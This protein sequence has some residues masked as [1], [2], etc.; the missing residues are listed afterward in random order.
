MQLLMIPGHDPS[1]LKSGDAGNRADE[2]VVEVGVAIS[3]GPLSPAR[4]EVALR[5]NTDRLAE[6]AKERVVAPEIRYEDFA[7]VAA[8]LDR[9]REGH[10]HVANVG[11]PDDRALELKAWPGNH[12]REAGQSRG[13]GTRWNGGRRG[14]GLGGHRRLGG[15]RSLSRS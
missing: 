7:V 12:L 14:R 2:R 13:R 4:P 3:A 1:V 9:P 15:D 6:L 10:T 5:P 8:R 11:L